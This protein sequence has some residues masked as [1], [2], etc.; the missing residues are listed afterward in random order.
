[1]FGF[2]IPDRIVR[3][4][5][6]SSDTG[7]RADKRDPGVGP[8]PR[9]KTGFAAAF[10]V[11]GATVPISA[12]ARRNIQPY[13]ER[14]R[15]RGYDRDHDDKSEKS[16]SDIHGETFREFGAIQNFSTRGVY[17]IE[18]TAIGEV[19]GLRGIPT[20]EFFRDRK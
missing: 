6:Q 18:D 13:I 16:P 12:L 17:L 5:E 10:V 2:D 14:Y 3:N 8:Q 4:R 11:A 9:E 7:G 19:L 1:M 20:A 15:G